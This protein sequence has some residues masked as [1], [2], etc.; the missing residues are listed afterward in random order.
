MAPQMRSPFQSYD[1]L[2][3]S[4]MSE[5]Q[6]RSIV[7]AIEESANF[8]FK[9]LAT[10]SDLFA[11]ESALRLEI[12]EVRT[13]IAELKTELKGD[14][15]NLRDELKSDTANLRNELKDEITSLRVELK[16]DIANLRVELKADIAHLDTKF[17][18]TDASLQ[19]IQKFL[20]GS[21]SILLITIIGSYFHH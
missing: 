15:A 20:Y 9:D 19:A 21:F 4:G 7:E 12:T 13:E 16:T 2:K 17:T 1:R 5:S 6:A 11:T 10:K 8:S 18:K 14:T 3:A